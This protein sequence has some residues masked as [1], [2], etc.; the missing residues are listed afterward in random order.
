M[1][2]VITTGSIIFMP[3]NTDQMDHDMR[4]LY[5]TDNHNFRL[6]YLFLWV[7]SHIVGMAMWMI[8]KKDEERGYRCNYSD[9]ILIIFYTI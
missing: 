5:G 8:M 7:T 9:L 3:C 4:T 2:I 1:T 6:N